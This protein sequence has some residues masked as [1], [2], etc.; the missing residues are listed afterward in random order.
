MRYQVVRQMTAEGR[1]RT[2]PCLYILQMVCA[3]YDYLV[4]WF[5]KEAGL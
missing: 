1:Q 4:V 2:P 3:S 5:G